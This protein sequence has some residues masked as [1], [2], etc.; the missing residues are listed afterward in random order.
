VVV[1]GGGDDGGVQFDELHLFC[2]P[3]AS[4]GRLRGYLWDEPVWT[5]ER[6]QVELRKASDKSVEWEQSVLRGALEVFWVNQATAPAEQPTPND[7]IGPTNAD[8]LGALRLSPLRYTNS[9]MIPKEM[10]CSRGATCAITQQQTT[11]RKE[12]RER[13]DQEIIAKGNAQ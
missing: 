5:L 3:G 6:C 4:S 9:H 11:K 13:N 2:L 7:S 8:R 1:D 12:G 10:P